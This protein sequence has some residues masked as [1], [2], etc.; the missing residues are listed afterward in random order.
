MRDEEILTG[1]N[2][3]QTTR[4][5][6][7]V[8]RTAGPWT[9]AIQRLLA[10]L[11]SRGIDW[12][13]EPFG[14]EDG[15]EVVG[16]LPG[17]VPGYP[18]P[19]WVWSDATLAACG[20]LLRK[21][22]DATADYTDPDALWRQPVREPAEVICHNDV[23]PYNM[24]FVDGRLSGLID[25]DMASPGPRLWDLAYLAYRIVPLTDATNPDD[26]P[27]DVTERFARLNSL[28]DAYETPFPKT[29]VL[30]MVQERLRH[31]AAFSDALAE[32]TGREELRRHAQIY[33]AD[34]GYVEGL[35]YE[36]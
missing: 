36:E 1:G 27:F 15:R 13:P 8:Y 19:D 28:I 12:V 11:R 17:V 25:F 2:V 35:L 9:P 30:Q 21:L 16:F 7:R 32:E 23:A 33:R 24:V 4:K 5:G 22:H 20:Q 6:D 26:G 31:L 34:V 14:M 29:D 18:M 10:H 3:G